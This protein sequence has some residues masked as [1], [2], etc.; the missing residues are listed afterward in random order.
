MEVSN[1]FASVK[2]TKQFVQEVEDF[3]NIIDDHT[4][5]QTDSLSEEFESPPL[6]LFTNLTI[7]SQKLKQMED[8]LSD[9]KD[10]DIITNEMNSD[11]ITEQSIFSFI[12]KN[13]EREWI[14][15]FFFNCFDVN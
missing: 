6:S 2:G 10:P 14:V 8:E 9:L 13:I 5:N 4:E 7:T 12:Q 11:K 15:L 1:F 3:Q